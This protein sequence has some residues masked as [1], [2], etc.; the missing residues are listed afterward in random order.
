MKSGAVKLISASRRTDIPAFYSRWFLARVRAGF[1]EWVNP[2]GGQV[3]RVSLRPEDC[4]GI[5]FW[6]RYPA[7]LRP[8][9]KFLREMGHRFYFHVTLNG[10]GP[11]LESHNPPP[12]KTVDAFRA[13]AQEIS[14]GLTF[15]RYDP[16]VLDETTGADYHRRKFEELSKVLEG[17]T[18]RCYFSFVTLYGKT[19]RN[20]AARG[21]VAAPAALDER[22][23]L[24]RDLRDMATARGITLYSCCQDALTGGG[25]EK[26]HCVDLSVL[27]DEPRLKAAP[28]RPDCGCA[29]ATDIGAYD[30]CPFG[31]AYCYA[32]N[33]RE[34]AL[35]RLGRHDPGDTLLWR[36]SKIAAS[37]QTE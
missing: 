11:R 15:W 1:C 8:H 20:L 29:Q 28:T 36:P 33:S 14:P 13:L 23:S 5:V 6:S 27:A 4:L 2:F 32:T 25:V 3:H 37:A 9:L 7:P 34:A 18:S 22:R 30:T 26:A 16:I 19:R 17:A 35:G 12:G 21:I 31:C 10:Y 24:V